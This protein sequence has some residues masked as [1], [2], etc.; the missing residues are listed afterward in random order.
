MKVYKAQMQMAKEFSSRLR[1]LGVPFFETKSELIRKARKN[2]VGD[3][4]DGPMDEKGTIDEA[5]LVKLQRQMLQ[6]L[7][8]LSSE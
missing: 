1:N 5:A 6:M 7:Q 4:T 8:D 2:G 3:R